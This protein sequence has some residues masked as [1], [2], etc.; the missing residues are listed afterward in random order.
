MTG[1]R[2]F[3][4]SQVTNPFQIEIIHFKLR[5]TVDDVKK[6]SFDRKMGQLKNHAY[7]QSFTIMG[8]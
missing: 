2:F 1:S 4:F 7:E 6:M 3:N 5:T 8:I